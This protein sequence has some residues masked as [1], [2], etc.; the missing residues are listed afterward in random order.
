[1]RMHWCFAMINGRLAH[2]FFDV[3]KDGNKHIF[4]HSY[5]KASELRTRREKEMMKNDVKK[6]R[7]S[8][9]NKKYRRLDA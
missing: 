8:Y 9:R 5:I 7:L 2:V 4:A 1:M 3:G 6:T